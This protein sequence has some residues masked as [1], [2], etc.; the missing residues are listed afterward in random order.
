MILSI[1]SEYQT[2]PDYRTLKIEEIRFLYSGIIDELVKA[3]RE[4]MKSEK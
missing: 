4:R 1:C 2:L 3:Q